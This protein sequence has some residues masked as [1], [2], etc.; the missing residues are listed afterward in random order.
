[1]SKKKDKGGKKELS[2][3]VLIEISHGEKTTMKSPLLAWKKRSRS[4]N[5]I[6]ERTKNGAERKRLKEGKKGD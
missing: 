5:S 6:G 2:K 3:S 4:E 1:M